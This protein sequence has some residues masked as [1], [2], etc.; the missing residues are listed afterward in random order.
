MKEAEVCAASTF[1][2]QLKIHIFKCQAQIFC[3]DNM[4]KSSPALR[5]LFEFSSQNKS[6]FELKSTLE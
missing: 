6:I 1:P 2:L 3:N 5:L 4:S